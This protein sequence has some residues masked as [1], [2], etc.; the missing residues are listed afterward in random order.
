VRSFGNYST[1]RRRSFFP[2]V[3][4]GFLRSEEV[5]ETGDAYIDSATAVVSEVEP[6]AEKFFTRIRYRARQ[7]R[8]NLPRNWRRP[9]FLIVCRIYAGT[10][11][12]GDLADF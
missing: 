2:S 6:F 8:W 9:V 11:R 10:G 12:I 7:D 4:R 3:V 5:V 1:A